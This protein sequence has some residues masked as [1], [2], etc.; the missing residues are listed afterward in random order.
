M[1]LVSYLY[2]NCDV[3]CSIALPVCSALKQ[4]GWSYITLAC[5]NVGAKSGIDLHNFFMFICKSLLN[6]TFMHI[7]VLR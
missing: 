2:E 5:K 1:T 7:V 4:S 6:Y 3:V